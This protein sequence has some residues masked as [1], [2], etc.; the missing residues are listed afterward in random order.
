MELDQEVYNRL[1]KIHLFKASPKTKALPDKK[2]VLLDPEA[3]VFLENGIA[4]AKY[5]MA[6]RELMV[7]YVLFNTGFR[8]STIKTSI[9][10]RK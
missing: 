7:S 2:K 5:C 10:M 9:W 3:T 6:L 4:Y 8:K 1:L